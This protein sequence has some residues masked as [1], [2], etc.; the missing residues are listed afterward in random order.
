[1]SHEFEMSYISL[2]I[3]FFQMTDSKNEIVN[4]SWNKSNKGGK[5]SLVNEM[6][7]FGLWL[8]YY[9]SSVESISSIQH[10]IALMHF[11]FY[12]FTATIVIIYK[13][14]NIQIL[15]RHLR[16]VYDQ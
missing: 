3:H 6:A 14:Q 9:Y 10:G 16:F 2:E 11:L 7:C 15:K 13:R 4:N 12:L 8:W 5:K 1:M